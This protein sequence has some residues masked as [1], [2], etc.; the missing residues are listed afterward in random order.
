M[1]WT[2]DD[3][4]LDVGCPQC[5]GR[6]HK[7]LGWLKEN[8]RYTCVCGAVIQL[9]ADYFRQAIAKAEN[10]LAHMDIAELERT[11]AEFERAISEM[12]QSDSPEA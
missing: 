3:T 5:R 4:L 6:F 2:I 11:R 12:N 8:A 7:T 1:S 9:D 10:A